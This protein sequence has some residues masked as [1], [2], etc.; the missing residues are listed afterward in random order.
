[1]IGRADRF[2]TPDEGRLRSITVGAYAGVPYDAVTAFHHHR[3]IVVRQMKQVTCA[4][5]RK[6]VG[7]VQAE[8]PDSWLSL[9]GHVGADVE[10]WEYREP[11][12]WWNEAWV[13]IFHAEGCYPQP[14]HTIE[15]LQL[16]RGWD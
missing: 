16:Q 4:A 1:M 10:F 3:G 8:E 7:S 2:V 5:H 9:G 14:R 11:G 13:C 6:R 12:Q 15:C